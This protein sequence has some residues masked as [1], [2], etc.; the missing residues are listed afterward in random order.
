MLLPDIRPRGIQRLV[1]EWDQRVEV[2]QVGGGEKKPKEEEKMAFQDLQQRR[3][4]PIGLL[5]QPPNQGLLHP[6]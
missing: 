1:E 5:K 4:L 3:T 6:R 2:P